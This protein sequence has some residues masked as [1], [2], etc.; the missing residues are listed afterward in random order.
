ML[1][2]GLVLVEGDS[3]EEEEEDGEEGEVPVFLVISFSRVLTLSFFG[4]YLGIGC[5]G[6]R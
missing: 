1:G 5:F 2:L 6:V 3:D 4:Y